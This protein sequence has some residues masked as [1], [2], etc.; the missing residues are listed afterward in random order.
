MWDG[1]PQKILVFNVNAEGP[2]SAGSVRI[3]KY[4]YKRG[5]DLMFFQEDFN[6]HDELMAVLED[7]IPA[8]P[9]VP[10]PAACAQNQSIEL[11]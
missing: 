11:T 10:L 3:G 8:R 1:L 7:M 9:A 2:G 4:L 6:Y 5:Y